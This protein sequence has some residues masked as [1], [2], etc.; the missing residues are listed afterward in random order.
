MTVASSGR[1]TFFHQRGANAAFR[2]LA[3]EFEDL[4]HRIFYLGYLLLLDALDLIEEDGATGASRLLAKAQSSGMATVVDLVSEESDRFREVVT[5]SLPHTDVLLTN[6]FEAGRLSGINLADFNP[7]SAREAAGI[8]RDL[9]VNRFVVIHAPGGSYALDCRSGAEYASGSV[10]MP[11]SEIKGAVGAGDAFATG[12][13]LGFYEDL[14]VT[15]SLRQAA[16]VAASC[17]RHP[18]TSG[19]I[20]PLKDC[21][22]LGERWGFRDF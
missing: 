6:E 21:L 8:L 3:L 15:Q 5:P 4:P 18:T 14:D 13:L 9:G 1:R 16:C 20:L 12:F 22:A 11:E 7:A 2:E 17:L 10:S 19:G